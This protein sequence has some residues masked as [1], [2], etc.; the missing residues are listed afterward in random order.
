MRQSAR[1]TAEFIRHHA[2][3]EPRVD[4]QARRTG[5]TVLTRLDRLFEN[6]RISQKIYA[7]AGRF[8]NDFERVAG[9]PPP[10]FGGV[11]SGVTPGART[12]PDDL[13]DAQER[14][15]RV[16]QVLGP[17]MALLEAVIVLDLSWRVIGRRRATTTYAAQTAFIDALERVEG[18]YA[19]RAED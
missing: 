17:E 18:I 15:R 10:A 9:L 14:L 11:M 5:W 3:L 6:A 2:V 7:A 4:R 1:P 8:R 12:P 19:E 13:L 16:A